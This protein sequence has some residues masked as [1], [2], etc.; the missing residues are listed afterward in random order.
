[1]STKKTERNKYFKEYILKGIFLHKLHMYEVRLCI[2]L[3]SQKTTLKDMSYDEKM[4]CS[5]SMRDY[6]KLA[7]AENNLIQLGLV[8][9][10]GTGLSLEGREF[11]EGKGIDVSECKSQ[12]ELFIRC[13]KYWYKGSN[14]VYIY[15]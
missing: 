9:K 3:T 5:A 8:N 15:I 12:R 11:V 13:L 6:A 2:F 1:M 7:D 14:I 4:W 10:D